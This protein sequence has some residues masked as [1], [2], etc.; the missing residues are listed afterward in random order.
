ML[1]RLW[2]DTANQV[3]SAVNQ[4]LDRGTAQPLVIHVSPLTERIYFWTFL[5]LDIK[6]LVNTEINILHGNLY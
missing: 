2:P 4:V 5:D 3:A 1:I 6:Y